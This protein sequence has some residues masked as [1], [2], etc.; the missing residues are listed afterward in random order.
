MV[1]ES[2]RPAASGK[3]RMMSQ[4]QL[5]GRI[6]M[7][8]GSTN[9]RPIV[10][11][12]APAVCL[13]IAPRPNAISAAAVTNSAQPMTAVSTVPGEI[14][15]VPKNFTMGAPLLPGPPWG[16]LMLTPCGIVTEWN[17]EALTPEPDMAAWPT[18]NETNEVTSETISVTV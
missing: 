6:W 7:M 13:M 5:S 18:K 3:N 14:T 9:S 16:G 11:V 4:R 15:M 10:E 8:I 12:I 2:T 1:T 17:S